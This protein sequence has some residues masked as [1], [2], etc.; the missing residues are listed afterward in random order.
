MPLDI[1]KAIADLDVEGGDSA[2]LGKELF[3]TLSTSEATDI[4]ALSEAVKGLLEQEP[5]MRDRA[6]EEDE[7][8]AKEE[9][10]AEDL[11]LGRISSSEMARFKGL[12]QAKQAN[13]AQLMQKVRYW[14]DRGDNARAQTYQRQVDAVMGQDILRKA[15]DAC[16]ENTHSA[17]WAT[18]KPYQ[19]TQGE[20]AKANG[21]G[22]QDN[23]YPKGSEAARKWKEGYTATHSAPYTQ[24]AADTVHAAGVVFITPDSEVLLLKRSDNGDHAGTW[25]W[26]GGVANDDEEPHQTARREAEEEIGFNPV[27]A[28]WEDMKPAHQAV[29]DEGVDYITHVCPVE[30]RFE[31][32]LN[33]EHDEAQWFP[34]DDL[35]DNLHPGIQQMMT[36][37]DAMPMMTPEE[38]RQR[39][40]QYHS[41]KHLKPSD[42][43]DYEEEL[44]AHARKGTP[45]SA[46]DE[47]LGGVMDPDFS[48]VNVDSDHDGPW[49]SCMSKDGKT[50][51]VHKLVPDE[52]EILGEKIDPATVLI[53]HEVPEWHDMMERLAEF[54]AEHA[55][56]PRVAE[57]KQIYLHAHNA[58]G[59]RCEREY[60][61]SQGINWDAW[62]AW[63]RGMEAK[64]EKA[65][66]KNVPDDADVWPVKHYH[67]DL[68]VTMDEYVTMDA[69]GFNEADHPRDKG[70]KFGSGGGGGR[71]KL[72]K[73]TPEVTEGPEPSQ[74][75]AGKPEGSAGG[76]ANP[77]ATKRVAAFLKAGGAKAALA[78][79][80]DAAKQHLIGS[81]NHAI[82]S[83]VVLPLVD[84]M[85]EHAIPHLLGLGAFHGAP[86]LAAT[87]VAGYAITK[88]MH[89]TGL[90]AHGAQKLLTK[91]VHGLIKFATAKG[92]EAPLSPIGDAAPE[93]DEE[94]CTA[95]QRF[96]EL[97]T[98]T[99]I[100]DLLTAGKDYDGDSDED[101][102]AEDELD[103][104]N[105]KSVL[106]VDSALALDW[107]TI[108]RNLLAELV[109]GREG[110]VFALDKSSMRSYDQDGRMHVENSH[111]SKANICPYLGKE[112]PN[113]EEL[114]LE[115]EKIYKLLRHPEE[116][117][118]AAPTFNGIQ[119][120]RKH[121]PVSADDHQP[122]DTIG[123][124]G[125]DANFNHPYLDN[126]LHIWPQFAI[127]DIEQK[128]KRELS[129]AYR[130]RADMTPGNYEGEAY[131]GVMRDIK[132]N[133]VALVEEG[134]AG[135]DV[136][137]GDSMPRQFRTKHDALQNAYEY[138]RGLA[139]AMD[140][141]VD[142]AGGS[143]AIKHGSPHM[144]ARARLAQRTGM[145]GGPAT[146]HPR[147]SQGARLDSGGHMK[148]PGNMS[149]P[150]KDHALWQDRTGKPLTEGDRVK[151]AQYGK[152]IIAGETD[153]YRADVD[154]MAHGTVP[155]VPVRE[156]EKL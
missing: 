17:H 9:P 65:T 18:D 29:S 77:K 134:R 81:T 121:N 78:K 3:N 84:H 135:N 114:G 44:N 86:A 133:H 71:Y 145:T 91:A 120:L 139:L 55:R 123:S 124:T 106:G 94:M 119:I 20:E 80:I 85:I 57:R 104:E 22:E 41:Q 75:G 6:E 109:V 67:G 27:S 99:D 127:S 28:R 136:A 110:I 50:M 103:S 126:S 107:S 105:D 15:F 30:N 61:K 32:E 143:N 150:S 144:N 98:K 59:T 47:L 60:C 96:L 73:A 142:P 79:S 151:H 149:W 122:Y 76:K 25:S 130:Y 156:L 125:T 54:K 49:M 111:I 42:D 37:N 69:E 95:L 74:G 33:E 115:G 82:E 100:D 131:D 52:V 38:G 118:K 116:L 14:N 132:G 148:V 108:P 36:A 4:D 140:A 101:E 92:G 35:P 83:A 43:P 62:S 146:K 153:K 1:K 31:C 13:V 48:Y 66:P 87:A 21:K 12:P 117:A 155:G 46:E 63:C 26:P 8:V 152:G 97:L 90:D 88:L 40:R 19:V 23:P 128:T 64:I 2:A 113:Y 147:S 10:Q 72:A 11:D 16:M 129:S 24:D 34:L 89:K 93:F 137:V 154:F 102:E 141:V 7:P 70:G 56:A 53:H 138:G 68:E 39:D 5:D 45:A 51:Y 58:C 112:I